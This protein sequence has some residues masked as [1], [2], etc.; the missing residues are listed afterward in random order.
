MIQIA[1]DFT[2]SYGERKLPMSLRDTLGQLFRRDA[3][4]LEN[5][6]VP[7]DHILSPTATV[8]EALGAQE[9]YFRLWV[10]QV[11]LQ[12]DRD[13]F[14]DWYPVVQSLTNFGLGTLPNVEIAQ[15]AGPSHL[16]NL[17]SAHLERIIQLDHALTPLV[18]FGGGTVQIQ[19]SMIAMQ[20]GDIVRRFLDVMGNFA[21]LVAIP[22][23]SAVVKIAD[24]V[25]SGVEQLLDVGTSQL[26][27]GYQQTFVSKGGGGGNDLS[28]RY[29]LLTSAPSGTYSQ[30]SSQ[31]WIKDGQVMVGPDSSSTRQLDKVNYM[32]LR[33][34]TRW[35]RDDWESLES[36][37]AP[38]TKAITTLSEVDSNGQI[39]A[40]DADI[41][42]RVAIAAALNSSD[43]TTND[44]LRV[45]GAIRQKY[46]DYKN[47]VLGPSA[48]DFSTPNRPTLTDVGNVARTV[49]VDYLRPEDLFSA[50]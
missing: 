9:G 35:E 29:L 7:L 25:S 42:V 49:N 3:Q 24:A 6:V 17:D 23:V 1:F 13:W 34:E 10:S 40:S 39:K 38:W 27:L 22:Q 16:P 2:A 48:K 8:N 43:L 50:L 5:F 20:S 31:I 44:K 46:T 45:A 28:A 30:P 11:F 4:H 41:A 36:I 32:L 26:V 47:I 12:H 37:N 21:G 15:V 14:K 33:V 18:P 19:A